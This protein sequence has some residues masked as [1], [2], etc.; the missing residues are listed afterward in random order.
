M[1]APVRVRAPSGLPE[2]AERAGGQARPCGARY[3]ISQPGRDMTQY[4]RMAEFVKI[5]SCDGVRSRSGSAPPSTSGAEP[6]RL[7]IAKA[8]LH[9][10]NRDGCAAVGLDTPP[11]RRGS[12][13]DAHRYFP[14]EEN[15]FSPLVAGGTADLANRLA[16]RPAEE[17]LVDAVGIHE[18]NHH[19][20]HTAIGGHPTRA[21]LTDLSGQYS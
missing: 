17:S 19:R 12:R 4:D 13:C 14:V 18:Y 9:L 7:E 21:R 3:W 6:G 11:T 2:L 10:Y 5:A 1:A 15:S 8:A 16:A 20:P